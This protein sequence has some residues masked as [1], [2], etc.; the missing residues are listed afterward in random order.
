MGIAFHWLPSLLPETIKVDSSCFRSFA[1]WADQT[2]SNGLSDWHLSAH[3][4]D[5]KC[6]SKYPHPSNGGQSDRTVASRT[7]HPETAI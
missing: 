5:V 1:V 7:D 2:C 4:G 6:L 3:V